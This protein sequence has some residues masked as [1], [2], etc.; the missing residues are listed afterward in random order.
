MKGKANASTPE[1]YIAAVEESRRD[2][3]QAL[4]D[5]VRSEAPELE[6]TMEFGMLGY[7]KFHYRYK[8]GREGDWMKIGI[9]NNKR[10]I[11]LYCCAADDDGYVAE[12]FRDRLPRA[13]IG[14]S[15][16][17]FKRLS[18][19]DEDA[20]RELIRVTASSGWGF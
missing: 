5:M 20:V 3:I 10:S 11:S 13:D 9:A 4:H 8:T 12:R 6:P 1:E 19:L 2:D 17:R 16:V 15:C 18:E 7:G 14:K